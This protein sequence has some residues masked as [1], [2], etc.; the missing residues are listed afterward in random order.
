MQPYLFPYIG[1]FQLIN[2]VDIFVIFDDV[3]FIKKGWINRNNILVN[4]T[5]NLFSVPLK[6]AS[7]NKLINQI[8]LADDN[9]W[10]LTFLKT[11]ELNYKKAPFFND[12]FL[13]IQKIINSPSITINDLIYTSILSINNYLNCKTE[14]IFSSSLTN[15]NHLKGQDKIIAICKTQMATLYIN[16]IG[17]KELYNIETFKQNG[18]RLN[19]LKSKQ[20]NYKQYN[21]DFVP[22]LSI[23]DVLMFNSKHDTLI[24]INEYTLL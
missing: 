1:Y 12:I 19:F 13:L 16:P 3:N 22:W 15:I 23:I 5:F 17:G 24:L 2:A 11:I 18:I 20:I 4:G 10:R 9:K 7:Q 6:E 8:Q 21:N 14:I